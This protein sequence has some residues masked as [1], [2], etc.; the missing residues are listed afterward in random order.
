[1]YWRRRALVAGQ[2]ARRL[3]ALRRQLPGPVPPRL[4]GPG[5]AAGPGPGHRGLRGRGGGSGLGV[6]HEDDELH[7]V[8]QV[9]LGQDVIFKAGDHGSISAHPGFYVKRNTHVFFDT[10]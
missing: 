9:Q 10:L 3:H 2:G 5:A 1:M 6:A 7:P 4:P 8:A